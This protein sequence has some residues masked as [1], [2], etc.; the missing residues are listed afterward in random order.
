MPDVVKANVANK[1]V[2]IYNKDIDFNI[3]E[4]KII[5]LR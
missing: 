1:S 2:P 5:E 3:F 4:I